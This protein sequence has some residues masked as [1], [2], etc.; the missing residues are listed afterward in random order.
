MSP[1]SPSPGSSLLPAAWQVPAAIRNRLGRDAGPQRAIFEDGHV[2][3]ILH[4]APPPDAVERKPAFF[5]RSPAGEWKTNRNVMPSGNMVDFLKTYEDR[6]LKL[7][8]NENVA[9]T[10]A[11]HHAVLEAVAPVL[12][13]VRGVHRSLQQ[14]RDLVKEDRE[15]I[16][17]RDRAAALERTAELLQ[18]DAQFGLSFIAARQSESQAE[19]AARMAITAHRLNIMAALFLPL[20][21]VA[22]VLSMDVHS[23]IP[24]SQ[25]NFWI[26]VAATVSLGLII[27]M[28]VRRKR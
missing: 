22:S 12:R 19:S 3:L 4:E 21:A 27:A 7:E 23:G 14:A 9:S 16:N 17:H 13:A 26:I 15:L 20:T 8:A 11:Q 5:W 2:L 6:L 1:L 25:Q 18:Q 28:T 24:N 10:A